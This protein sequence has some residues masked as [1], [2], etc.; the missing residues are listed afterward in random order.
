MTALLSLSP[1]FENWAKL[2]YTTQTNRVN[3]AR[4]TLEATPA[5]RKSEFQ[6][7]VEKPL[8]RLVDFL[9]NTQRVGPGAADGIG[10]E[11]LR[12]RQWAEILQPLKDYL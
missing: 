3:Q 6:R 5:E 1:N 2:A 7:R 9:V 10:E 11:E 8:Q 4:L 12:A